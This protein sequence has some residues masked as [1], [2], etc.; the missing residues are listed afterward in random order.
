MLLQPHV[1][2]IR[3]QP[4]LDAYQRGTVFRHTF[5]VR[6][7]TSLAPSLLLRERGLPVRIHSKRLDL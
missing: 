7:A 1:N 4:V 5:T 6:W 3:W 2:A